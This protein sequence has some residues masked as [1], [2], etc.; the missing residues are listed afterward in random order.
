MPKRKTHTA[1]MIAEQRIRRGGETL[2]HVYYTRWSPNDRPADLGHM[3]MR[4]KVSA[5]LG[6]ESAAGLDF[7]NEEMQ[8]ITRAA[9][10]AAIECIRKR[11]KKR[12]T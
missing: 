8:S 6:L 11:L 10:F 4:G 12:K 7:S 5:D 1:G 2:I 3:V 9:K